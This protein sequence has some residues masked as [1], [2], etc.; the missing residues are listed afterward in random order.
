MLDPHDTRLISALVVLRDRLNP[1]IEQLLAGKLEQPGRDE[2]AA[3]FRAL[4][5]ELN[6]IVETLADEQ[7]APPWPGWPERG[8]F[9]VS[10]P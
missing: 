6:H 1:V 5:G 4:A 3:M 9:S 7:A 2:L 8:R 10:G